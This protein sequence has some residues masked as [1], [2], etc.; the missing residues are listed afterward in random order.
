MSDTPNPGETTRAARWAA[1]MSGY[2]GEIRLGGRSIRYRVPR[3]AVRDGIV[4][5]TED[6]KLEGFFETMSI[7]ENLQINLAAAGLNHS[8]IVDMGGLCAL[9]RHWV[10]A[11]TLA[12][13]TPSCMPS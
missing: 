6:R 2:G 4:Y 7:A 10:E 13:S 12:G 5:V 1:T 3:Q 11:L 8:S 9:S